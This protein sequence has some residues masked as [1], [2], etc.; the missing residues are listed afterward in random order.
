MCSGALICGRRST[1]PASASGSSGPSPCEAPPDLS[2]TH[3]AEFEDGAVPIRPD[4]LN[5]LGFWGCC[6]LSSE[7]GG[8][9]ESTCPRAVAAD[10][11]RLRPEERR[12]GKEW[13]KPCSSRRWPVH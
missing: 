4:S 11:V 9:F 7:D 10:P 5:S 12:V 13:V 8:D 3:L 1:L 2:P 6:P